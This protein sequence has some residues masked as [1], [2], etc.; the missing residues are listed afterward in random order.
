M[1]AFYR[2]ALGLPTLEQTADVVRLDAGG[3]VLALHAV[4]AHHA[5]TIVI[6]EPAVPRASSPVKV[7]FHTEDVRA[8]RALLAAGG[9][10]MRDLQDH[11]GRLSFDCLDPEG[12]VFRIQN[13]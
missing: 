6:A 4:P 13:R 8:A 1:H 11:D 3:V 9:A 2:E 10:Q 5:T 12:N 7:I